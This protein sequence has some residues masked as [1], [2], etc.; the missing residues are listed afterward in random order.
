MSLLSHKREIKMKEV[1]KEI[2]TEQVIYE[3]TKEEL[4][5]IKREERDK[6]RYDVADYLAFSIKN[7]RYELNLKG[8]TN[9]ISDI[10]DFITYKT[11]I[12]ENVYECSF[13]EYVRRYKE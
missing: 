10:I 7:Y 11:D 5:E 8:V 2:I 3:I 12:V 13:D 6:G 4:E 9:L 1:K